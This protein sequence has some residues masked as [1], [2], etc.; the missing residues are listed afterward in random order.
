MNTNEKR[1]LKELVEAPQGELSPAHFVNG[2]AK[3][4]QRAVRHL[5]SRGY[6]ATTPRQHRDISGS[7]YDIPF[8][9][10]TDKGFAEF[11]PWYEKLWFAIK[12]DLRIIIISAITSAITS[13]ITIILTKVF[14]H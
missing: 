1:I 13:L 2:I 14:S 11:Y 12:S 5:Q 4:D 9:Y 8:Y 10:A 6:I 3:Q 7:Y